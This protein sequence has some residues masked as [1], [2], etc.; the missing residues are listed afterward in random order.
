MSFSCGAPLMPA[1][2]S[3]CRRLK[4]LINLLLA[5]VDMLPVL[6]VKYEWLHKVF[7]LQTRASQGARPFKEGAKKFALVTRFI[8]GNFAVEF[9]I[10]GD[11]KISEREKTARSAMQ[12]LVHLAEL[13]AWITCTL[14]VPFHHI[15]QSGCRAWRRQ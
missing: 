5:G 1:G 10:L 9:A 12:L 14:Q 2:G 6:C 15:L 8:K 7:T 11:S 4:S 3:V 13:R